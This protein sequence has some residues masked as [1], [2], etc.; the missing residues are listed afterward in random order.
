[1][2]FPIERVASC[3]LSADDPSSTCDLASQP[4]TGEIEQCSDPA[5]AAAHPALCR[6]YPRLRIQPSLAT[7]LVNEDVDFQAF[8]T[9]GG[10]EQALDDDSGVVWTLSDQTVA[11]IGG[12]SGK[13]TGVTAGTV[14]ISAVWQNLTASAQLTVLA[15]GG[16]GAGCQGKHVGVVVVLDKSKSMSQGFGG[17]FSSKLA[18]GKAAA[19]LLANSLDLTK[20]TIGLVSFHATA[21]EELGLTTDLAAFETAVNGVAQSENGTSLLS[22]VRAAVEMLEAA[23]NDYSVVALITDGNDSGLFGSNSVPAELRTAVPNTMSLAVLGTRASGPGF[24]LLRDLTINGFFVNGYAEGGVENGADEAFA[25]LKR[26]FCGC[27][28]TT[29]PCASIFMPRLNYTGFANWEVTGLVDLIGGFEPWTLFDFLPGNGLYPDMVGSPNPGQSG[30]GR[31]TLKASQQPTF[32]AAA[33]YTLTV[34]LAG[35]QREGSATQVKLKVGTLL[36]EQSV[37]FAAS[38]WTQDFTDHEYEFVGDGAAHAVEIWQSRGCVNPAFGN[39]LKSVTIRNADTDALVFHDV[40]N[41]ENYQAVDCGAVDCGGHGFWNGYRCVYRCQEVTVPTA[42]PDPA[43]LTDNESEAAPDFWTSQQTYTRTCAEG[44]LVTGTGTAS[45]SL[46]QAHADAQALA[47]AQ[48]AAVCPSGEL[49]PN[50]F[51]LIHFERGMNYGSE[52]AARWPT[53]RIKGLGL[54]P[55][56]ATNDVWNQPSVDLLEGVLAQIDNGFYLEDNGGATTSSWMPVEYSS[57]QHLSGVSSTHYAPISLGQAGPEFYQRTEVM[58][59]EQYRTIHNL[60]AGNY[61]VYVWGAARNADG[62]DGGLATTQMYGGRFNLEVLDA[63]GAVDTDLG[64]K[65]HTLADPDVL[66]NWPLVEDQDYVR[67]SVAPVPAGGSLRVTVKQPSGGGWLVIS[68]IQIQR[69]P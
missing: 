38:D 21:T 44:I 65:E 30:L 14:Q 26:Y 57:L 9:Q 41:T 4:N 11:V 28:E 24:H 10:I 20:D 25:Q 55:V 36:A 54:V 45:S 22:G 31:L 29:R 64:A 42:Q 27:G 50:D 60:P 17:G 49:A 18:Y 61:D 51:I 66:S 32:T 58:Q 15:A 33:N 43:P 6:N 63:D 46:S 7:V 40:F 39:L 47:R 23:G 16:E 13:A 3:R 48:A 68:G 67:W 59:E 34:R 37:N 56:G 19:K 35:N 52:D 12:R 2:K 53:T 8:V 62:K 5:F 69:F 1:M